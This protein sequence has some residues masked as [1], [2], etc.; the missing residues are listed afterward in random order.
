MSRD[1]DVVLYGAT[2]FTG[3]QT[4]AYFASHAPSGLR[5]AIAGRSQVR[6]N[7]LGAKVPVLTADAS[8][9]QAIDAIVSRTR[10]LLSTAG[11]F[12]L[13]G[14]G[15]VDAC[16]RLRTHY[17]DIT[18]E[19][20]WVRMLIDRYHEK[21]YAEG[22]RIIPCCGFDSVPSDLGAM[23]IAEALGP[24][25]R[26]VKAF[27]KMRGGL[28][29][30]TLASMM[31]MYESGADK[32]MN[33]L[34]LLSPGVTRAPR[35]LEL[36]PSKETYDTD[37]KSWTAPF[38]MSK[39]NTRVVRRSCELLGLDFAYQ[40]YTKF[41]GAFAGPV[42]LITTAGSSLFGHAMEYPGMRRALRTISPAPG[43]G[44]STHTMDHGWF[45]CELFGRASNGRTAQAVVADQGDPGNRV[46][47]K[48]LCE[49]ALALA[50]DQLPDR[51]GVLTPSTGLGAA[52][53]TR[54]RA[55]GME[56]KLLP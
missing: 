29:G 8:D 53:V 44:P 51:A 10:V 11:P 18:G 23:L 17:V 16:V 41:D 33:D 1:F 5:W 30:G 48:C 32:T 52:L 42:A 25:T 6:L 26:E 28:N 55:R 47:V 54:L 46:T 19:T 15:F 2:G 21:A 36:D 38:L 9:Q 50:L 31:N 49:S 34:F 37:V 20:H 39:I 7:A 56:L 22:T 13:Y 40:E 43:E 14:T 4:V 24:E 3:R 12:A 27:F 35:D 45:R